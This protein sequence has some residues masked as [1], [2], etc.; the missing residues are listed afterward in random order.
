MVVVGGGGWAG[1]IEL[2]GESYY[3]S[4]RSPLQGT[5]TTT[6]SQSRNWQLASGEENGESGNPSSSSSMRLNSTTKLHILCY[7]ESIV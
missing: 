2:Q 5:Q 6:I 4:G 7:R 3:H 1:I